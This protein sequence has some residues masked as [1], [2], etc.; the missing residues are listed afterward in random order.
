VRSGTPIEG[1]E[2]VVVGR[3]NIVGKPISI[4]LAQKA[5]AANATVT[6]VHTK[7]KDLKAHCLR[8]DILIVA[9][10]VPHL[11]KPEWIKPGAT[12][13]DVASTAWACTRRRARRFCAATWTSR[14]PARSRARSR[15]SRAAWDR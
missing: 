7:T 5:K 9:A 8:A 12:V 6:I 3:S 14:R 2:V 13:I 10:G 11:V 4:M 15:R 1:A